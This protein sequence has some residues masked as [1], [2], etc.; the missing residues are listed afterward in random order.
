MIYDESNKLW[1]SEAI[2][3]PFIRSCQAWLP[4]NCPICFDSIVNDHATCLPCNHEFCTTC[5]QRYFELK[6]DELNQKRDNPFI[7]PI[8]SCRHI[9]PIVK[10]VKPHLSKD[11]MVKVRKWY[12]NLTY[13]PCYSL[14]E[15]LR[16][17]CS[18]CVH[19]ASIDSNLIYCEDCMTRWCE[20]CLKRVKDDVHDDKDCDVSLCIEFCQRYLAANE[21]SKKQCEEKWPF[22][23]LY[24]HSQIHDL[25]AIQW[26]QKNG[27]VCPGCKSGIER[28]EG[29]FHIQC[30]ICD[31]HFCYECGV[32]L[33]P[34][35]YGTHHWWE[36]ND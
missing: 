7:C 2:L 24:A 1:N 19:K 16:R 20:L 12:V 35:Y 36:R 21:E 31:I 32:Q 18:G 4:R 25:T 30:S 17:D 28:S 15:C 9:L 23:K 33:F 3:F 6:V 34:P 8:S 11:N 5:I 29:C 10:C 26:V 22:V 13:P 27:Q 14:P